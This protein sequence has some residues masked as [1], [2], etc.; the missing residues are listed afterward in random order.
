MVSLGTSGCCCKDAGLAAMQILL[1]LHSGCAPHD[2]TGQ[3]VKRCASS[4]RRQHRHLCSQPP[5]QRVQLGTEGG[6]R[7]LV[8]HVLTRG[9]AGALRGCT[10]AGARQAN[11]V[12]MSSVRCA[13]HPGLPASAAPPR[14]MQRAWGRTGSRSRRAQRSPWAPRWRTPRLGAALPSPR[15]AR[16]QSARSAC[17]AVRQRARRSTHA[18]RACT[19]RRA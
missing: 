19:R 18:T 10:R 8:L 17:G 9:D 16:G 5:D 7:K 6:S 2:E 3:H 14:R 4:S 15:A 11:S 1:N 13:H 12:R